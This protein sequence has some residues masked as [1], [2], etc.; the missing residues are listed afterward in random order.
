MVDSGGQYNF[1]TTDV[2]T[3]V[4]LDNAQHRIR[5]IFTRVLKGHIGVAN[6]KLNKNTDGSK[7]DI[8]ARKYLKKI[9]L[10]YAHGTGHGVGYFLNVHEGPHAISRGNK[11]KFKVG[12]IVS[13]EPGYYENGK[14]GI[15]IE[16][17]ITVKKIK[18]KIKFDDLTLA[19][20]DKSLVE[21]NLLSKN[22]ISWLNYYHSKV[23]NDLKKFMNKEELIELKSSCSNI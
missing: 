5:N 13:N 18:E 16:N 9:N 4:S 15:R 6:Y 3:T 23:F 1:G 8:T 2:T 21:K 11:I 22:E 7:I 14:F 10:D 17:L 19:P 20:I 12:M